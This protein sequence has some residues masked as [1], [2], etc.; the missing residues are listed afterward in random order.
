M[1]DSI[2][3]SRH[4]HRRAREASEVSVE[5]L[6]LADYANTLRRHERNPPN[7]AMAPDFYSPRYQTG[8]L[9]QVNYESDLP[10]RERPFSVENVASRKSSIRPPPTLSSAQSGS[11]TTSLNS[12]GPYPTTRRHL[13]LPPI[14]ASADPT[15]WAANRPN[16]SFNRNP[17]PS[18]PTVGDVP[19][20]MPQPSIDP[21]I[22]SFPK[23]ARGWYDSGTKTRSLETPS[24]PPER[25]LGVW[26]PAPPPFSE[27]GTL[28]GRN[29]TISPYPDTLPWGSSVGDPPQYVPESV[30][31]ERIRMLERE[32][33][34]GS[35]KVGAKGKERAGDEEAVIGGVDSEGKLITPG[36]RRRLAARI[37]QATLALTAGASGIYSAVAMRPKETPPPASKPPAYVIYVLSVLTFLLSV[38]FFF[39]LP[40]MRRRKRGKFNPE[41]AQQGIPGMMVLPMIQQF[42]GKKHKKGKGG[43]KGKG[44]AAGD[45][46][47]VNLIVTPDMLGGD[48]N[49]SGKSSRRKNRDEDS[50]SDDDGLTQSARGGTSK[51][52]NVFEALTMEND[53]KRA[54]KAVKWN[55][56]VDAILAL[57]WAV[58]FVFILWGE[59]CPPG[60]YE[61]WCEAYNTSTA[62]AFFLALAFGCSVFF[63]FRDLVT[64]KVSP[65]QR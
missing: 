45:G 39:I 26:P 33:G 49:G 27:P 10:S 23:W 17:A 32:F 54:R 58:E 6:D 8:R 53:W 63:D 2:P 18:N 35:P 19:P 20:Q 56:V 47:Q 44:T 25:D 62:C 38:Y 3:P 24:S 51:R 7:A 46:V 30:K 61:G 37:L 57:A 28:Y 1:E 5:A 42:G 41:Q 13:S 65:R 31:E 15:M 36:P 34:D 11:R 50:D 64:S 22:R 59:R 9:P 40:C 4:H 21:D 12:Q 16:Q 43:K 55:V 48:R 14:L 60:K 52:R 29:S